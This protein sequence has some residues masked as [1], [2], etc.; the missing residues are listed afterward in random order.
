MI[1]ECPQCG[2]TGVF[3]SYPVYLSDGRAVFLC[4]KCYEEHCYKVRKLYAQDEDGY[5][6]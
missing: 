2:F 6:R 4:P 1:L 5:G 3:T